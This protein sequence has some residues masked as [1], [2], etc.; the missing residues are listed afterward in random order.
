MTTLRSSRQHENVLV[1]SLAV[2]LVE[3]VFGKNVWDVGLAISESWCA[4]AAYPD[5]VTDAAGGVCT[6]CAPSCLDLQINPVLTQQWWIGG[7]ELLYLAYNGC[8]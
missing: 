6:I 2:V 4:Y 8:A 7:A 1:S 3:Q 5:H